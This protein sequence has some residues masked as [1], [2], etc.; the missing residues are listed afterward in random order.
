MLSTHFRPQRARFGA[1][2]GHLQRQ[3]YIILN[4]SPNFTANYYEIFPLAQPHAAPTC[5]QPITLLHF[6]TINI[7]FFKITQVLLLLMLWKLWIT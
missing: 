2:E 3:S 5:Q 6:K 4:P 1:A 7:V